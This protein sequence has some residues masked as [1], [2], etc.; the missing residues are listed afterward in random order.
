MHAEAVL[1]VYKTKHPPDKILKLEYKCMLAAVTSHTFRICNVFDAQTVE[2]AAG[3]E[4]VIVFDATFE[5]N[6]S[7]RSTTD[8]KCVVEEKQPQHLLMRVHSEKH[9][10]VVTS[11]DNTILRASK[12]IL[13]CHTAYWNLRRQSEVS[14]EHSQGALA[15]VC[16]I[17]EG[18][19]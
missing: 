9:V 1:N 16:S 10:R 13:R 14:T 17:R 6:V 18:S 15:G 4:D 2:S 7:C 3:F 8:D 12:Y 5:W 11:Y 19:T